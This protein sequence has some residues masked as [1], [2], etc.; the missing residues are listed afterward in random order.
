MTAHC[1]RVRALLDDL[2]DGTP[3]DAASASEARRHLA[4]CDACRAE[5]RSLCE[6]VGRAAALPQS[7]EPPRDLWPGIL[8]RIE[9]RP[10]ATRGDGRPAWPMLAAASLTVALVT[11]GIGWALLRAPRPASTA[12][13][14]SHDGGAVPVSQPAAG[15]TAV[16]AAEQ[17]LVRAK[18]ELEE[19]LRA[20]R[21]SMS[22]EAAAT[23]ERN[24]KVME[25]AVGEIR[26]ALERDPGNTDLERMLVAARRRELDL[27]ERVTARAVGL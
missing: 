5:E 1:D 4:A 14:R 7:I 24:L 18:L 26:E 12:A 17:A 9:Q 19:V 20:R 2:V 16:D 21:G 13:A 3:V 10:R 8:D 11:G 25:K 15:S 6:L 27:L 22:P 23:V